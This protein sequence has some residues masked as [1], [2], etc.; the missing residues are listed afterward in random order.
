MARGK[1][2]KQQTPAAGWERVR[3]DAVIGLRWAGIA[4]GVFFAVTVLWVGVYRFVNPPTTF[5]IAATSFSDAKIRHRN[6]PIEA[7][8][9]ALWQ[10]IVAAEDQRFCEHSGF[11]VKQINKA[12]EEAQDGGRQRG[13]STVSQQTAKNAFLWPG[14]NYL[15]KGLEAYFTFLLETLWPKRRI[16]EVYLNIVEFGPGIFGA[17]AASERYFSKPARDLN[18]HEAALLAAV[19]PNPHRLHVQAPGPYVQERAVNIAALARVLH[20]QGFARCVLH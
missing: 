20:N 1:D 10:S 14:R 3:R 16:M 17:E 4:L 2:K 12:I 18:S 9:P 7:V 8:A 15:R 6:V 11:D 13:A 19:L 5:L